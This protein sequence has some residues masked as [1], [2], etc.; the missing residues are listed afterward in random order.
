MIYACLETGCSGNRSGRSMPPAKNQHWVSQFYLR[1][2]ATPETRGK[3]AAS[4]VWIF[5]CDEGDGDETL[6]NIRNICA[7]RYL[8]TPV[9]SSGER[10]WDLDK[11]L[12][13]LEEM[14]GGFWPAIADSFVD[15][16]DS[17]VRKGVAL[18][19]AILHL[20]NP[21]TLKALEDVH[22]Q[23]VRFFDDGPK[24]SDGTPDLDSIE[25]AGKI[26]E[27]DTTGWHAYRAWGKN[28]HQRLFVEFIQGEATR[29][30]EMLLTKRWSMVFAERDTFI[31]SDK[32]VG[33]QHRTK[34]N[35]GFGT[36]GTILTF[37]VSPRRLL[38][39]D[40]LH[41]EPANQYYP[42]KPSLAGVHN[43]L[44]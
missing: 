12:E 18:F 17:D 4:Q 15:L 16:G 8:Y 19:V 25:I 2:F 27:V 23:L 14:A 34:T 3:D 1:H 43:Y 21:A 5:S 26:H 7:K 33:L 13:D 41:H 29:I 35:Y 44:L 10:A 24:R 30:A 28:D 11:K 31:T 42:L 38:V 32:P 39:M 22:H 6:T 9:G 36:P 40:D 37:P 20:R